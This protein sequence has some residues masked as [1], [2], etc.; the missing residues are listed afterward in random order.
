MIEPLELRIAPA[1]VIFTDLDGDKVTVSTSKGSNEDLAAALTFSVLADVP[2]QLQK[3]DLSGNPIFAGTKLSVIATRTGPGGDGLT[4]V[5]FIDADATNGGTAIDLGAVVIDGDLGRITAGTGAAATSVKALTVGSFGLLGTTTQAAGGLL[6]GTFAGAIGA[7]AIKTDLVNADI[8][9]NSMGAV[10]IGGSIFGDSDGRLFATGKIASILIGGSVVGGNGTDSGS[11]SAGEAGSVT[12]RGSLV[13]GDG[14]AAG[15]IILQKAGA[16]LIGGD[17]RGGTSIDAGRIEVAGSVA[18]LTIR[19]SILSD[20]VI[21]GSAATVG[22]EDVGA[23]VIGG[24]IEQR[25]SGSASL[26]VDD[27][28]SISIG[29]D[30]RGG[31]VSAEAVGKFNLRGSMIGAFVADSGSFGAESVKSIFIGGTLEGGQGVN[32]GRLEVGAAG[33]VRVGGI[34]GGSAAGAGSI[35]LNTGLTPA[36][37]NSLLVAGDVRGGTV[38]S[39]GTIVVGGEVGAFELRGSLVGGTGDIITLIPSATGG[40][41]IEVIGNVGTFK[42]SGDL[43]AGAGDNTAIVAIGGTVKAVTIGGSIVGNSFAEGSA[44]GGRFFATGNIG[45][46]A[47]GGSAVGDGVDSGKILSNGSIGT[48]TIR[49]GIGGGEGARSGIVRALGGVVKALTLDGSL[50]GG[51]GLDSG[52][53]LLEGAVSKAAIL[54]RGDVRGGEGENS[55]GVEISTGASKVTIEGS[56]VGGSGDLSAR[57]SVFS[58]SPTPVS[59]LSFLLKGDVRGGVGGGSGV[60]LLST[61]LTSK[62]VVNGSVIGGIG[63]GAGVLEFGTGAAMTIG[64]S[65]LGGTGNFAGRIEMSDVAKLTI[66]GDLRGS[67]GNGSGIITAGDIGVL[68]IGGSILGGTHNLGTIGVLNVGNLTV[69]GQILGLDTAPVIIEIFRTG[70]VSVGGSVTFGRIQG[71][72]DIDT[73][74]N[75]DGQITSVTVGGDWIG[76]DIVVGALPGAGNRFGDGND[77]FVLNGNDDPNVFA[78]IGAI[79]IG[80]R[81]RGTSVGGDSFA[82]LAQEIGSLTIAG[83]KVALAAG[84]SN[85]DFLLGATLDHVVRE[86]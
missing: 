1:T 37:L 21:A 42:V 57:L 68:A 23:V 47:L 19:G 25:N 36:K 48:L 9:A 5:G 65:I 14:I 28:K 50:R 61:S 29:G 60:I 4:A 24:S 3:I 82:F 75:S 58:P 76:S 49:G 39:A 77:T 33:A 27:A 2:R 70:K 13:G 81:L 8:A 51:D 78:R 46:F 18:S 69:G 44:G 52:Q 17:L 53:I 72:F 7:L 62:A 30:V 31:R 20:G 43:R 35:L 55:G 40:G 32:S 15:R 6:G 67:V 66:R 41:Q 59:P 79:V 22:I 16:I 80:G 54:I 38:G 12:I 34:F 10:K 73:G 83:E 11:I 56:V 63:D 86:L 74:T 85:D 26:N 64:G 84:R 45:T 71:G